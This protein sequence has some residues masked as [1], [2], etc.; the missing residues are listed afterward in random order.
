MP[1]LATEL[2]HDLERAVIAARETAE[3]GAQNALVVLGAHQEISIGAPSRA[4]ILQ[5]ASN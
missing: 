3:T 5:P 2:R 1:P 4:A